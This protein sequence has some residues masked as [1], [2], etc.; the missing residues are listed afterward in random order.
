MLAVLSGAP[1][2]PVLIQGSGRVW[3]K[4]RRF[5]RPG[6]VIVTFGAPLR[7]ERRDDV[8][9]K[10]QY[11]AASRAMMAAIARLRDTGDAPRGS[12]PS[13]SDIRPFEVVGGPGANARDSSKSTYGR[14]RQHE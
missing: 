8:D 4:G 9:K 3:P 1:V 6:R 10:Q 7:F 2:V 5:P 12:A 13:P 11:E 14:K